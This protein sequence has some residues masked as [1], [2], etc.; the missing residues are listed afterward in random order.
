[1]IVI[2]E[3]YRYIAINKEIEMNCMDK[4]LKRVKISK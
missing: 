2:K 1:M 4:N 3:K